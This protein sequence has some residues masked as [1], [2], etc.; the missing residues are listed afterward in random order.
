MDTFVG[1]GTVT[2]PF[3]GQAAALAGFV[4]SPSSLA[5]VGK[6]LAI[7]TYAGLFEVKLT[8]GPL[9][10]IAGGSPPSE[11]VPESG[12]A[13]GAGLAISAIAE[14]PRGGLVVSLERVPRLFHL[15]PSD[16]LLRAIAA[17]DATSTDRGKV[18]R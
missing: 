18:L 7:G 17:R 14:H 6:A 16:G 10:L 3:S 4:P 2:G 9:R 12:P 8:G 13:V 15:S 1:G 5:V 11:D